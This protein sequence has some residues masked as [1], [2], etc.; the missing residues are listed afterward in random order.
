MNLSQAEWR[1][2]S[3]TIRLEHEC[4]HYFTYRVLGSMRNN[5]LD[6]LIADY[7][8]IVSAIGKYRAD[9]FLRFMGLESL[10]EI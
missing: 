1:R 7:Q 2:L 4:T 5:L 6:E 9:W 3:I 8:G 10:F